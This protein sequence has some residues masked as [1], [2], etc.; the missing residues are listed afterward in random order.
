MISPTTPTGSAEMADFPIGS[1]PNDAK[2]VERVEMLVA[3]GFFLV[4]LVLRWFYVTNQPWDSDEP[5]HLHVVWAWANGMLPYKD[6]FDNHAPLFQAI[7]APV[8]ALF[9]ECTDI[10]T[11][12]RW[13]IM[14]VSVLVLLMIYHIGLQ[15]FS[16][17]V[18]LWGAVLTGSFPDLYFK[19]NEYR[20]DVFWCAVWLILLWIL[21]CGKLTPGRMFWAGFVLGVAF[22]ASMKTLFLFVTV[23]FGAATVWLLRKINP[24]LRRG[25]ETS[26]WIFIAPLLG[27]LIV[28]FAVIAF[29][30]WKDSVSQ[31]YYCVIIHNMAARGDQWSLFLH[32]TYDLRFWLFIP[33]IAGGLWMA[34][35]DENRQRALNRLFFMSVTGLYCP[36][37]F[38]F[39]P[40]I[41][42]QDFL[43]FFPILILVLT[44][45]LVWIGEWIEAKTP[46]PAFLLPATV[47][48]WQLAGM[49]GARPPLKPTNQT[50]F[51]I[52]SD[53]LRLTHP[54]E[55]VL[56]AKGQS[57]FRPRPFYYVFEQITREKVE[58]GELADDA[59]DRLT[60]DRTPVIVSSHWLTSAT[61]RF[62]SENYVAA[63]SVMVLGKKLFPGKDGHV[64]FDVVIPAKYAMISANGF[65]SGLLDGIKL[66]GSRDL[67]PGPHKLDL[68]VPA[69]PAFLVWSRALEKGFSPFSE[70]K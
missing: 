26:A 34:K 68:A 58:R 24:E 20:P 46:L 10:V 69:E 48:V 37:L 47:A 66:N 53:V 30:C 8:F 12:M 51:A 49:M 1:S 29:F 57:I 62:V 31:M 36:L 50:N 17:R 7:S 32:R 54:G 5:Q 6:V 2:P 9:G 43:P 16:R 23:L 45:P 42:K 35:R 21:T 4:L 65:V 60:A 25:Q 64:E 61:G 13:A 39:W 67:S 63:G 52:I 28:P 11:K 38:S 27:V 70:T 41:S 3:V 15:L 22:A 59:P 18:A 33:A 40:L 44:C 56:D 19:L 14:P 55:T